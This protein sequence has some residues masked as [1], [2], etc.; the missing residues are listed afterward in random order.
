MRALAV[1]AMVY[2]A[3]DTV[4]PDPTGLAMTAPIWARF[5]IAG[6]WTVAAIGLVAFYKVEPRQ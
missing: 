5:A 1:I 2:T 3:V 4:F 6:S